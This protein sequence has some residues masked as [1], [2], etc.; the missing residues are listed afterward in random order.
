MKAYKMNLEDGIV[1]TSLDLEGLETPKFGHHANRRYA[2]KTARDTRDVTG[3][4]EGEI[5]D[6]FG[7]DQRL[8]Q[9]KSQLH[10]HGRNDRLKRARIT[11]ML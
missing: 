9:R 6:F 3:C 7:W 4:D 5:D 11:M 10:Y 1:D 8:R 2:D